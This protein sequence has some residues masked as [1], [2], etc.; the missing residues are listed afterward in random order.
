MKKLL[1]TSILVLCQVFLVAQSCLPQGITISYQWQ[2]DDFQTNYPN[3][4][5]IEGDVKINGNNITNLIGLNVLTSIGG[6]LL[7]GSSFLG[8]YHFGNPLLT[9]LAGLENV[10][11]IGGSLEII[12]NTALT[13]LLGLDNLS[14]IIEDLWVMGNASLTNLI[15]LKN[16]NSVG[17]DIGIIE[18]DVLSNL[19]GLD[20]LSFIGRDLWIGKYD[21]SGNSSGNPSLTG[22]DGLNNLVSVGGGHIY[23]RQYPLDQFSWFR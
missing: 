16:V 12:Y 5:E 22:L 11:S 9:N 6:D 19:E 18:N 2:I 21:I 8:S 17:R 20:N 7:I 23:F 3:C 10:T 15:G 13:N 1:L 4:T 14:S